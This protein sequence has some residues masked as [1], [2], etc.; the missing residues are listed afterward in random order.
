M[1]AD[2]KGKANPDGRPTIHPGAIVQCRY[3]PSAGT[4]AFAVDGS[5]IGTCFTGLRG[6]RLFPAVGFY[7]SDRTVTLVRAGE[8]DPPLARVATGGAAAGAGAPAPSTLAVLPSTAFQYF[9]GGVKGPRFSTTLSS[10]FTFSADNRTVRSTVRENRMAIVDRTF[11][12][13]RAVWEFRIDKD[14]PENQCVTVGAI[15]AGATSRAYDTDTSL[16]LRGYSGGV[17]GRGKTGVTGRKFS[18]G[19]VVRVQWDGL[20]GTITMFVNC[21]PCGI[22]HRGLVGVTVQPAVVTYSNDRSV[23]L[24]RC[25]EV[26]SFPPESA[27]EVWYRPSSGPAFDASASSPTSNM[28][29]TPVLRQARSTGGT[30]SMAVYDCRLRSCYAVVE[31]RLDK[32]ENA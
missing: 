3:D 1:R 18:V 31:F 6:K 7:S 30:N 21:L 27:Y 8:G 17:Y 9:D 26:Q 15:I 10:S 19:D 28:E 2:G 20:A 5:E 11:G 29:F 23:S 24:L 32:D 16:Q 12:P 14:E 4:L 25:V 22:T 13:T